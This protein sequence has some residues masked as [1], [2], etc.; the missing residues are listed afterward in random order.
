MH[1]I[2]CICRR[3]VC[4]CFHLCCTNI[5]YCHSLNICCLTSFYSPPLHW[6]TQSDLK[7]CTAFVKKIKSGAYPT[8]T[9]LS[10]PNNP[11]KTLNLTRYVEE[12]AAAIIEPSQKIKPSDV[13]G[14]VLLC[15]EMHRRYD[16]FASVLVPSLMSSVTGQGSEDENTL[17]KR[18]CLRI[19]TEFVLHGIITDLK[20]IIKIVSDAA[21]ATD[22]KEYVVTDPNLVVTFAK[23]GG[24]ELTGVVPRTFR[25]ECEKLQKEIDGKGEGLID[26]IRES[27]VDQTSEPNQE[28]KSNIENTDLETPFVPSLPI[29]FITEARSIIDEYNSITSNSVAV[30]KPTSNILHTHCDGAY[31]SLS[32]SYLATHKRLLKLEKRCDQDRLL[33]GNLSEAREKGLTDARTLLENLKKSVDTLSDILDVDPPVLQSSDDDEEGNAESGDGKGISLWTKNENDTDENL[34]PFD[35]EETRAFYCDVPDLLSTKPAALL[36]LSPADLEKQKE[37]NERQYGGLGGGDEAED[38]AM[39][40]DEV[41]TKDA[42]PEESNEDDAEDAAMDE[43]ADGETEEGGKNLCKLVV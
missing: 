28:E 26:M 35:D 16:G 40:V 42:D 27:G 43:K 21:G 33:Q 24:L 7:K 22:G 41:D 31:R 20:P 11:I 25:A 8:S 18:L 34:G 14:L 10:S 32:N 3:L 37:R 39:E 2:C 13:P 6:H 23:T 36:G 17:P 30:P 19:L 1:I 4:L 5:G 9:E 38:V 12:V 29:K 15:V